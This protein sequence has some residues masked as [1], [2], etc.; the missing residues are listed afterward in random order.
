MR[1]WLH[2]ISIK[3][4]SHLTDGH[5][6]SFPGFFGVRV[7]NS[8][9]R[10]YMVFECQGDKMSLGE[11]QRGGK[12]QSAPCRYQHFRMQLCYPAQLSNCSIGG[13]IR[14]ELII[15]FPRR[16]SR[17]SNHEPYQAVTQPTREAQPDGLRSPIV[18]RYPPR[19]RY[20]SLLQA[21]L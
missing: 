18:L 15:L 21:L 1:R 5:I 13:L 6:W 16:I 9:V 8:T 14:S 2:V 10:E 3:K 4:R 19:S 11:N 17:H 12:E 7:G 20:D